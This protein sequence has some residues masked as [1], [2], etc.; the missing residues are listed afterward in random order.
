VREAP[1]APTSLGN[2]TVVASRRP[3]GLPEEPTNADVRFAVL[4]A[5]WPVTKLRRLAQCQH[6]PIKHTGME[7]P[8]RMSE[9]DAGE[10][11]CGVGG[12]V[13]CG[14]WHS[15]P[16]CAAKI[17]LH[18]SAELAHGLQAWAHAGHSVGL[19]TLTMRHNRGHALKELVAVARKAWRHTTSGKRWV[20]EQAHFG[21]EWIIRV[22][23]CTV[24]DEHGWHPHF[25]VLVF[26]DRPVSRETIFELGKRMWMR[27]DAKLET[28]GCDSDRLKGGMDAR[29]MKRGQES[30]LG[31]YAFK[32]AIEAFGQSF[33]RGH[34]EESGHRHRTPFQ[35]MEDF[36]VAALHGQPDSEDARADLT[37]IHEW[38]TTMVNARMQHGRWP[39]G[40]REVLTALAQEHKLAGPLYEGEKTDEE[41]AEEEV[42]GSVTIGWLSTAEYMRFIA[43]E[44]DTLRLACRQGGA[45]AVARWF[46]QRGYILRLARDGTE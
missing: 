26:F 39:P 45:A 41:I 20:R 21:V 5:L 42:K 24:G 7:L 38:Q 33:K 40:L 17:A 19:I 2:E 35:V 28:L 31:H 32:L 12:L 30:V 11:D 4:R 8:L 27:W 23:E 29:M 14:Y 36:A 37:M 10:L 22:F 34:V 9:N 43:Y 44:L 6:N 18:R 15:C 1:Q 46:D 16:R 25:H 3:A 13:A